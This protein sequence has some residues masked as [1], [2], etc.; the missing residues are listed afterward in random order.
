MAAASLKAFYVI[1]QMKKSTFLSLNRKEKWIIS[2]YVL[3]E[4]EQDYLST[5]TPEYLPSGKSMGT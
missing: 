1:S 2:E 3:C 5:S 4:T